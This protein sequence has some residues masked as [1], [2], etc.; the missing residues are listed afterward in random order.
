VP[1]RVPELAE[2]R[3]RVADIRVLSASRTSTH[4][5][6]S[7][8]R[9]VDSPGVGIDLPDTEELDT[10]HVSASPRVHTKLRTQT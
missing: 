5:L 4:T 8:L 6:L 10:H 3:A 1:E 7:P 9:M 2:P